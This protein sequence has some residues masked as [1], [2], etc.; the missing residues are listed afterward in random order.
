MDKS[1]YNIYA[2]GIERILT[3][4]CIIALIIIGGII[5]GK[6]Q[7]TLVFLVFSLPNIAIYIALAASLIIVFLRA[8]VTH[9]NHPISDNQKHKMR[10][11]ARILV[12]VECAAIAA[13]VYF[14]CEYAGA[15]FMACFTTALLSV[16]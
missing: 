13:M 8:P 1:K 6:L 10:V 14:N 7:H 9:K 16:F 12:T 4:A 5:I 2:Y 3:N 15:S 11:A